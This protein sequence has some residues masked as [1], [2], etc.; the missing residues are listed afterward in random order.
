MIFV[1]IEFIYFNF[2]IQIACESKSGII[3]L[4][5]TNYNIG[6]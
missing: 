4:L 5:N 1:R 2:L 3:V 6:I